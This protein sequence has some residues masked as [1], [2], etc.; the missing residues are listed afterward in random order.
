MVAV[1][2]TDRIFL[3]DWGAKTAGGYGIRD[4]LIKAGFIGISFVDVDPFEVSLSSSLGD[5][6]VTVVVGCFGVST[7]SIVL[8]SFCCR[9]AIDVDEPRVFLDGLPVMMVVCT[10]LELKDD[11]R[12]LSSLY[13]ARC[14]LGFL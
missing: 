11:S 5:F 14:S 8:F 2:V 4:G 7:T 3:V 6:F 9:M 10:L 12:S 13:F 1:D